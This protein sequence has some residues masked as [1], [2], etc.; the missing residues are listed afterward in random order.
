MKR[1]AVVVGVVAALCLGS[2]MAHADGAGTFNAKCAMCHKPDGKKLAK[3]MSWKGKL[4]DAEIA[5]VCKYFAATFKIDAA[6]CV[7]TVNTGK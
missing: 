4:S 5:D 3:M 1:I 2:V 7:E 6:K